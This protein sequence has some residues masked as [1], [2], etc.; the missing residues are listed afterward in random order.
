MPS[1]IEITPSVLSLTALGQTGQ[2]TARVYDANNRALNDATVTWSSSAPAVATVSAQGL[3]TA[4]KAGRARVT[5]RSGNVSSAIDVSVSQTAAG[6]TVEPSSVTFTAIAD[7]IQLTAS[8]LDAE[9][10]PVPDAAVVWSSDDAGIATVDSQ[11]LVT[12]VRNGST[13]ITAQSEGVSRDVAVVVSQVARRIAIEPSDTTLTALGDKVQLNATAYDSNDY[14]IPDAE[15]S[16]SSQSPAS[17]SVDSLGVATALQN[18]DALITATSGEATASVLITVMA[19]DPD[20][21]V[22]IAFYEK[23]NGANWVSSTNWLSDKPLSEWENVS[24]DESGRVTTLWLEA[25]NLSGTIPAELAGLSR[26]EFLH[27]AGN[28]LSGSIPAELG[29]LSSLDLLF[30][31]DNQLSGAIPPEMGQLQ[32]IVHLS[33]ADNPSLT[34]P[35]PRTFLSLAPDF[36]D[37]RNTALCIPSDVEFQEWFLQ[38]TGSPSAAT[39]ESMVSDRDI[40]VA[41]YGKLDGDNWTER[42]NWLT[43]APVGE[44]YGIE[45]DS[46]GGIRA[47][48]L[49]DNQLAGV[50]P[51]EL[52]QLNNLESLDLSSNAL[53]GPLPVVL[54]RLDNLARLQL[55]HNIGLTGILPE[56]MTELRNLEQ[57]MLHGTQL[58]AQDDFWIQDWLEGIA[59]RR[60][61]NCSDLESERIAL[62]ALYSQTQGFQISWTM[63]EG[64]ASNERVG[65]WYGVTTNEDGFVTGL[66]LTDNGL[67]GRIPN[68]IYLLAHL[69]R[70]E[71]SDNPYLG[72]PLPAEIVRLNLDTLALTGTQLCFSEGDDFQEWLST[73]DDARYETCGV[74]N[75]HPDVDALTA[76]FNATNGPGWDNKNNWLSHSPLETWYGI[77]L[78]EEGRVTE[79]NMFSND[80]EGEI[81]PEIGELTELRRL[82]LEQNNVTGRLP[83]EIGKLHNLETLILMYNDLSGSIPPE[84]GQLG[85]L[86]TLLLFENSLTGSIPPEIGQLSNLETLRLDHNDLE[87]NIPGEIGQLT[88][89]NLL[90]LG[91]NGLSGHIPEEIGQLSNLTLLDLSEGLLTG[92]IPRELWQLNKLE[93]LVLSINRLSGSISSEIALLTNLKEL[94]IRFNEDMSGRL[95]HQMT[96]LNLTHLLT[97][98]TS[99]CTPA[100]AEFQAWLQR[101]S[102]KE[103]ADPCPL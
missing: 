68:E 8:V 62:D 33:L 89:L 96:S 98:G 64:W 16:W 26:L 90:F 81:P 6:I 46:E 53:T 66:N 34:G 100:D 40:L 103:L 86:K 42:H 67:R 48:T 65:S 47:I 78:G 29:Q 32:Q 39:C 70:L 31:S 63:N 41:L 99:V 69:A 15:F 22:L 83:S 12:A 7:T 37:I 9:N 35:L 93:H 84:I 91:A 23:L 20:R 13:Q 51:S 56:S 71:L 4:I 101:I 10:V 36:L 58:C 3:V 5:A 49:K 76:F 55:Q 73:I 30:L 82:Y 75:P 72:G 27:L 43:E 25:N 87:G 50:I 38:I 11:G 88:N 77:V 60:V 94:D 14:V 24:T 85:S 92:T 95:P 2:L 74:I 18:G 61:T 19:A 21:D 52:V 28:A 79:I 57:L 45:T 17:V 97:R 44:W 59:E 54:G 80:L 102:L 1:G